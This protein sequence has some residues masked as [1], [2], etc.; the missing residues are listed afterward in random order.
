MSDTSSPHDDIAV[1][2]WVRLPIIVAA[3]GIPLYWFATFSG[4]YRWFAEWQLAALGR[5]WVM[6]TVGAVLITALSA[7][8]MV[9]EGIGALL[10][11]SRDTDD[12]SSNTSRTRRR[13]RLAQMVMAAAGLVG[14]AMLAMAAWLA[15]FGEVPGEPEEVSLDQLAAEEGSTE[16]FVAVAARPMLN[17][18]LTVKPA[19]NLTEDVD[20]Y[21]PVAPASSGVPVRLFVRVPDDELER[22][23]SELGEKP[24]VGMLRRAELPK[25]VAAAWRAR[26][27][28]LPQSHWI[29]DW[30][31]A[32][33]NQRDAS[34]PLAAGGVILLGAA[35]SYW[36]RLQRTTSGARLEETQK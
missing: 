2:L 16:R 1:P 30:E 28:D 5:F 4:P 13:W 11:R 18:R 31:S 32:P 25:S 14:A 26:G 24:M 10:P 33:T 27:N 34:A 8:V 19:V 36:R 7:G 29:L 20:H 17:R 12:S 15:F 3:F 22:A 21:V 6:P 9:S 35:I 23:N